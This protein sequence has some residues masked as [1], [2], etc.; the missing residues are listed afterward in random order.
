MENPVI[1]QEVLPPPPK[2]INK[3]RTIGSRVCLAGQGPEQCDVM[4]IATTVED[5]DV[6]TELNFSMGSGVKLKQTPR[7]FKGP[8]GVMFKDLASSANIQMDECF[9][10]ALCRWSLPKEQ[11]GKPKSHDIDWGRD[12]LEYE[13]ATVK[14][15]LIVA[16]GKPVFD[17]LMDIKMAARDLD[18][19]GFFRCEKHNCLVYPLPDTYQLVTRPERMERFRIDLVEIRR[20]RDDLLGYPITRIP[21]NYKTITNNQELTEFVDQMLADKVVV[22]SPDCEWHGANHVSGKLRSLQLSW[23][24]GH[25]VYIRFMDDKLNYAFDIDYK[26]VGAILSRWLDKPEVKYIGHHISADLPWMHH[27]LGL[28]WYQKAL[29]DTEFALQVVDEYAD[30]GLERLALAYTDLGRYDLDLVLWKKKTKADVSEGYGFIPDEILIPYALKDVDVCIRTYPILMQKLAQQDLLNYYTKIFNPFVTDVFTNFAL[31]GLPMDI[32]RMDELRDLYSF[33]KDEMASILSSMIHKEARGFLLETI[34]SSSPDPT[35]AKLIYDQIVHLV[36]GQEVDLAFGLFKDMVGAAKLGELECVFWHYVDSPNFNIRSTPEMRRWL[37]D[38]KGYTP[39]KTTNQ[40]A[41]GM[42]TMSW[43]KVLMMPEDKQRLFTPSVDTQSLQILSEIHKDEILEYLLELNAVGNISKGMLKEP[44][45]DDEGNLTRENGLHFWLS[46]DGRVHG[47]MSTTETG[48][49][50]CVHEDTLVR[51]RSGYKRIAEVKVGDEVWTHMGRWRRVTATYIKPVCEM[52]DVTFS[53]GKV[54]RCTDGH[55]LLTQSGKWVSLR[56]VRLQEAFQQP[57]FGGKSHSS[58]SRND[59]DSGAGSEALQHHTPHYLRHSEEGDASRGV[60]KDESSEIRGIQ[61]WGEE[62]MV[63][64]SRERSSCVEG[65][66]PRRVWLSDEE[67]WIEAIFRS[68]DCD[69]GSVGNSPIEVTG[70]SVGA[71]H[72]RE[73]S[74]QQFGQSC[75]VQQSGAQGFASEVSTHSLGVEIE[76]IDYSGCYPVFD[77]SVEEDASYEAAGCFSHNSWKPNTLNWPSRTAK[78]IASGIGKLFK[79]LHEERRLPEKFIH[80]VTDKKPIPSIRSCVKPPE[81]W[82]FVE[83]DFETAEV[84]GLAFISGDENLI[85][86]ITEPDSNFAIYDSEEKDIVRLSFDPNSLIELP[87]QDDFLVM[88][89]SRGGQRIKIKEEQLVHNKDGRIKHPKADLHWALAERVAGAPREGLVK[90]DRD[91]SKVTRFSSTYGA[92]ASTLSRKI[93]ADT[94]NKLSEEE[95][96]ALLDGLAAMQPIAESYLIMLQNVPESPGFWRA[97]SG[98]LRRFIKHPDNLM[99]I[100]S[101]QRDGAMGA[102]GREARNWP[103]QE[104]VA[105]AAGVAGVR[106]VDFGIVNNLQG[107][108]ITILYDSCVTLCPLEERHLWSKAHELFMYWS[109]GWWVKGGL[110]RYPCESEF[111]VGWSENPDDELKTLWDSEDYCPTPDTLKYLDDWLVDSIKYYQDYPNASVFNQK[112]IDNLTA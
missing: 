36:T 39:V 108:P 62:S 107:R 76:K 28:Q 67:G 23:L 72:R 46:P 2:T 8:A 94:G 53:N 55:L 109:N 86:M 77:I 111:N 14:P 100:S 57:K 112:D 98:R 102:M 26:A 60:S 73:P 106:L 104:S 27:V 12:M 52:Y 85:K 43:E 97:A 110:L 90:K 54:L 10:T 83:S 74:E 99:G 80:Y 65:R 51:C 38:I 24:P 7:F 32:N 50:R 68:S 6:A 49:P 92:T 35:V 31:V 105:S 71:S 25:A 9:Y 11:R 58:V 44:T 64:E 40:K 84:R 41:K 70:Q 20:M 61:N 45:L 93:Y 101:R 4:F 87:K 82:C 59:S 89:I 48:R 95:G 22:V 16:I 5:A 88:T 33:A 34:V 78:K 69:G 37:F 79:M 56:N 29:M 21:L 91:A 75:V 81:G 103:F 15:K 17:F 47:Q 42:P 63:R 66:L 30:L 1:P 19:G 18:G 3:T 13:I 96:Q